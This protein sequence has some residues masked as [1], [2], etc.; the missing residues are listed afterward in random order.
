MFDPFERTVRRKLRQLVKQRVRMVLQ[1][2][3]YWV[4]DNTGEQ[5][6]DTHAALMTC[7][8]RGW[9]EPLEHAVPSKSLPAD[10]KLPRDWDFD[11]METQ[12]RLTSAGW[13]AIHR[14]N[15]IAIV[16]LCIS[17]LSFVLVLVRF[18]KGS[19]L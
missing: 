5:S 6:E 3:N 13:S 17:A 19:V 2:G 7:Y 4:I 16:A 11:R 15:T 10:L 12:Y 9:I 1:P 8:M 14:T 18:G